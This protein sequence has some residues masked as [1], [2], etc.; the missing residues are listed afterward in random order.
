MRQPVLCWS[1][2]VDTPVAVGMTITLRDQAYPVV[3]LGQNRPALQ[4]PAEL[5]PARISHPVRVHA[6][7]HKCLTMY[8]RQFYRRCAKY[9]FASSRR[10]KH[11]YHRIDAFYLDCH[12]NALSSVSGHAIDLDRFDDIRVVRFIRDPRDLL[13]SGYFYHRRGAEHW[14]LLDHAID[15]DY[16]L[17]NGRVPSTL[18][19]EQNLM[20]YLNEVSLEEGLLAEM[21][22]RERHYQSMLAWPDDDPRVRLF[23]Y[24]NIIGNEKQVFG[25]ICRFMEMPA[26][27]RWQ[28]VR[29]AWRKR[30]KRHMSKSTH[31][32]NPNAGQRRQYFTPELNRIF[33]DRY[34]DVLERY[35]YPL[36]L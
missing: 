1:C 17:V 33:V 14:C 7:Y 16:Q 9:W 27:A 34:G 20:D 26:L 22:F 32:R 28:G 2:T 18:P 4:I 29:N 23:K 36:T 21:D 35:G 8:S 5:I 13:I 3:A 25:D 11:Y 6:G 15:A 19:A 30:A 31:I 12:R 10:F 24:E